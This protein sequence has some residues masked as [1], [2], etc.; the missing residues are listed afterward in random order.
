MYSGTKVVQV[1]K[2]V[3]KR[4]AN[5]GINGS[6]SDSDQQQLDVAVALVVRTGFMTTKGALVRSMLFPKPSGFKFYQDSFK[7][8][9]VMACVAIFGFL[10]SVVNFVKMG[11]STKLIVF[12]AL[13]LITIVV[14]PALPATLTIGTNISLSRLREKKIFC[15]SPSRVN[16]GGKLDVV[17]FDKTGTLTEDGLDVLGVHVQENGRFSDLLQTAEEVFPYENLAFTDSES[18]VSNGKA[19]ERNSLKGSPKTYPHPSIEQNYKS[20]IQQRSSIIAALTT[21]HQL[22]KIDDELLGDPLDHKMFSF[23]NWNFDEEVGA[24]LLL[25]TLHMKIQFQ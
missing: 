4:S 18:I 20:R 17:C 2:P 1:R 8:I 9:G 13:D 22:R 15:I 10:H 14:P 16:V 19:K 5:G 12:R 3:P 11:M 24:T 6:N 23:T 7:Y 21:C 25:P